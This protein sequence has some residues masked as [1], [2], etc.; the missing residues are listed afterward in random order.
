MKNKNFDTEMVHYMARIDKIALLTRKEENDLGRQVKFHGNRKAAEKLAVSNLRFVV[1]IALEYKKFGFGLIDLV[2]EGN[3]GLMKAIESFD[4]EKGNR[5]ITYAVW[6]IRAHIHNYIIQNWSLVRFG[7]SRL[8]R[9]IFYKI[10]SAKAGLIDETA[11][12]FNERVASE[13]TTNP[14]RVEEMQSRVHMR[15]SSLDLELT[16]D[17]KVRLVDLIASGDPTHAELF[18]TGDWGSYVR[19]RLY[20]SIS[21][22][23][24]RE[25]F[26]V[27][28]RFLSESPATLQEIGVD[29]GIS[30]ER[31]RQLETRIISRL[32]KELTGDVEIGK[33]EVA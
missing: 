2:Q 16:D 6:W 33:A 25:K 31:V 24:D 1:K 17:G 4:P 15:D 22:L 30:K 20:D 12:Q 27:S 11:T 29:L 18:E 32:R 21:R 9:N 8:Q 3:L 26:I 28:R 23:D 10:I 7:S 14:R 19:S 5:L 13:L